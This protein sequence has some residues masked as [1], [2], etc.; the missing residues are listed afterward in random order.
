[1]AFTWAL[2]YPWI[3]IKDE[4]WLK[5]AMLYW[6]KIQTIVPAS[7]EQPYSARTAN[8]FYDE[9]LLVP[10]R[11][12]PGMQEVEELT[13]DVLDYLNSTEGLEV[14]MGKEISKHTYIYPE[15]LPQEIRELVTIHPEKLP[16]EIQH[17]IQTDISSREGDW[18][19]V[20]EAGRL[21]ELS[22]V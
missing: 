20:D 3:D 21:D 19:N 14:L 22:N 6:E 11:V 9:G 1:M 15:K 16:Y 4:G 17:R 18:I 10:F 5:S 7:I 8:E 12:K 13:D 2:Y